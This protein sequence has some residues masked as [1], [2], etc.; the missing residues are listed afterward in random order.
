[1]KYAKYINRTQLEYAPNPIHYNGQDIFTTDASPYGY[2]AVITTQP[3]GEAEEG[4]Y[5]S[6]Y[7]VDGETITQE[8]EQIRIEPTVS[9]LDEVDAQATYTALVTDT[10]LED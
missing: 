2:K 1:M 4:Y 7:W 3:S 8:W 9:E 6:P 5:W 10:L